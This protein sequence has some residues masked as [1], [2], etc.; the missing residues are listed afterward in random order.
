M[1][2]K[3]LVVICTLA[4]LIGSLYVPM[5]IGAASAMQVADGEKVV[6]DFTDNCVTD[7]ENASEAQS[8][9]SGFFSWAGVSGT[10]KGDSSNK[11]LTFKKTAVQTWYTSGG[12]KL[13]KKNGEGVYEAYELSPNTSY[14]VSMRVRVNSVTSDNKSVAVYLGYGTNYWEPLAG[15]KG[16]YINGM[17]VKAQPVITCVGDGSS[18]DLYIDNNN[19]R[20]SKELGVW[21][22]IS[23]VI[24][25]PES[26]KN[27]KALGFW[28]ELYTGIDI[29]I[30]DVSVQK[31]G[32][33]KGAIVLN[34]IYSSNVEIVVG[35]V[36][37]TY[38]LPDI[39]D[40]ALE[41]EHSFE[42][43]SANEERTEDVTEV[44][45]AK[46]V[47]TVY[48]KW[49]APVKI[50]FKDTL[51]NTETVVEGLP[52]QDIQF[53]EDP[54]NPENTSWFMGW[55]TSD[56]YTEEYAETTF[57][58]SN[59]VL[60]SYFKGTVAGLTQNFEN[61]PESKWTPITSSSGAVTKSNYQ[62]FGIALEK[63][64]VDGTTAVKLDW[65]S[66]MTKDTSNPETYDAVTRYNVDNYFYIGG[67]LANKESYILTFKYK[68]EKAN[69]DVTFIV[70]S[71]TYGGYW[72]RRKGQGSITLTPKVSDEWQ[73]GTILFNSDFVV[74]GSS[75]FNSMFF[76]VSLNSNADTVIYF[77]DFKI[78]ALAQPYE[79]AIIFEQQ[80][81]KD[82]IYAKG[83][84]GSE[85][86]FPTVTHPDEAEFDG[87]YLD[88]ECKTPFTA[89][90]YGKESVTLYAKWKNIPMTFVDYPYSTTNSNNFGVKTMSI[91]K[92]IGVGYND[93][94]A[95]R[96]TFRGDS[97]YKVDDKGYITYM[98]T[99]GVMPE[100]TF[101][102]TSIEDGK[103]YKVTYKY[104]VENAN[105]DFTI[106]LMSGWGEN[107]WV[108]A[109]NN[110]YTEANNL[111][112]ESS[113]DWKE[114]TGYFLSNIKVDGQNH[115]GSMLFMQIYQEDADMDTS[116]DLLI[117]NV[118]VQ[119]V[120]YSAVFFEGNGADDTIIVGDAGDSFTAPVPTLSNMLFVDW[121]ADEA[122][123]QK[124]NLT[125]IPD[126]IVKAYAKWKNGPLSFKDY[127]HST[128]NSN[129]FGVKTMSIDKTVGYNDSYALRFK[130]RGSDVYKVDDKGNVTYMYDRGQNLDHSFKV[131]NLEDNKLYKITYKYKVENANND[132]EI[133]PYS[134]WGEN[135]W[136]YAC[137]SMYTEAYNHVTESSTGWK[138]FTGY[139]LSNIKDDGKNHVG[140]ML[141]MQ[142]YQKDAD[143]D[144][145]IDLLIDDIMIEESD[146]PYVKFNSTETQ[147]TLCVGK[148]GDEIKY[149][150]PKVVFGTDFDGW[151]LDKGFSKP[152]TQ[153]TFT[154][155]TFLQIYA[156]T[157]PSKVLTY[158][159]ENYWATP[160]GTTN[161]AYHLVDA[162]RVK[163]DSAYSGD[164][165]IEF[166]R[167]NGISAISGAVIE[168]GADKFAVQDG[169]NYIA[170]VRYKV[171]VPSTV[172]TT[173]S[174]KTAHHYNLWGKYSSVA[175]SLSILPTEETG[176]WKTATF[177][178]DSSKRIIDKEVDDYRTLFVT[179]GGGIGGVL[180]IDDIS[181]E[182]IPD[183][184]TAVY[185]H[186][187]GCKDIPQILIGREGE[188]FAN[189]VPTSPSMKGYVFRGYYI[190]QADGSMKQL[191]T[192]ELK[193]TKNPLIVYAT[194]IKSEIKQT[195]EQDYV[196]LINNAPEYSLYDFDFELYDKL[197]D[198]NS[199]DNVTS[200]RY[201]MHRK[202]LNY[203]V[204]RFSV[205]TMGNN[206]EANEKYKITF[207]VKIGKYLHTDGAIKLANIRTY[208]YAWATSGE[209]KSV[210]AIKDI[211][212]GQWHEVS[213]TF[214]SVESFI[215]LQTPGY[216]ELFIDD[217]TLTLLDSSAELSKEPEFTEYVPVKRDLV[218]GEVLETDESMIDIMTIV[219]STLREEDFANSANLTI[220]IIIGAAALLVI[221]A[222]VV[223]IVIMKKKK[224]AI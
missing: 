216:V 15:N 62:Q 35:N 121:Y 214:A 10:E 39:S 41:A 65:D 88:K 33:T 159:I 180:H 191:T 206:I 118:L 175:P 209:V 43:W 122:L 96:F 177:V 46:E 51:N 104:K 154:A 67:G 156:K 127:P 81:G 110:L 53:P 75:T 120:D 64:T 171:V 144:T 137:N 76:N 172:T 80:N 149:P 145:V 82:A 37:D 223:L 199:A 17:S 166:D 195:F 212:D 13:H 60:Y 55:Y 188:S 112:T 187:N 14:V 132:F 16:N 114:F 108:S 222:G 201:S 87:W 59:M 72:S 3:V 140:S 213:F 158:T 170:T 176:V 58:F 123:T 22:T 23:Y 94:A 192:E 40:R 134:A 42:G 89:T 29:E 133:R 68:V 50:T 7:A 194:F 20:N 101:R 182:A 189:K 224:K 138:E 169:V 211:A 197:K 196:N 186:N 146:L 98:Y 190:K 49:T 44:T 27:E 135:V 99:R 207:K 106:R 48:S 24:T 119:Q 9:G 155:D 150:T 148:A 178:I 193:Y 210:V 215:A 95:M 5:S 129:T 136:V 56:S 2:K 183:G 151:Y 97:E 45:F 32:S 131:N 86:S 11:V 184:K 70:A 205:L 152:F 168:E 111:V 117:D 93:N 103:I 141:F 19:K 217:I 30:D 221:G 130:F 77:D 198:G 85:I 115:V 28:G 21:Q 71:A 113:T 165:V 174:F 143:M 125:T 208:S 142:I 91:D 78:E 153:T 34:D 219:D 204:E 12:Y 74:E 57:G 90:V 157:V 147:Y 84:K 52:G 107:F 220:Y 26:W 92:T 181:I 200:G 83:N 124:F 47:Q 179:V 116:I 161:G 202:G 18:Y 6:F 8:S 54:V 102:T 4:L 73:T 79:S 164:Y 109:C 69:C 126:G 63:V 218:T 128:T 203:T 162:E 66:T 163:S 173:I 185:I 31:I 61:Y 160:H 105:N 100:H 25:T 38:T 1:L 167:R 36:G 139:F